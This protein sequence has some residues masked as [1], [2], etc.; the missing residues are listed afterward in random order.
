MMTGEELAAVAAAVAAARKKGGGGIAVIAVNC[1]GG[2]GNDTF[3]VP[4]QGEA[5]RG[6]GSAAARMPLWR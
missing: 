1:S 4:W 6:E 5:R 2:V 3:W